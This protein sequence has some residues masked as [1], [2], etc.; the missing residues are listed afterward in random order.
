MK[1][2]QIT[3]KRILIIASVI[4]FLA[5]VIYVILI[6]TFA[7]NLE[8]YTEITFVSPNQALVFWKTEKDT[9]GYIKYG[10]SRF[11]ITQTE[12]QTSSAAGQTHVV[13]LEN[14]PLNGIYLKKFHENQNILIFPKIEKIK[15]SEI[16]EINE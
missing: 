6:N 1:K 2:I 5:L 11:K 15:Y 10:N 4:L 3:K 7:R 12:L 16:N 8:K 14:I 13:F 9:L